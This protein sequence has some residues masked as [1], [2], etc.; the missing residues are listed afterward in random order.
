MEKKRSFEEI[1]KDAPVPQRELLQAFRETH[2][3]KKIVINGL[4]WEYISSGQGDQALLILGGGLSLGESSFRSI[5]H[6]ENRY[7]VISPSYPATDNTDLVLQGLQAILREEG[8]SYA[9]VMGHS[10]GSGVGH[11]FVRMC[12]ESVD[13]LVLDAFGLYTPAHVLIARLFFKLPFRWLMAYYRRA[14]RRLLSAAEDDDQK[15][16]AI[17]IGEVMNQLHTP[18]SLMYQ[19]KLLVDIFNK[20]KEYKV[21]EPIHKP[22]KVL[23]ILAEDDKGFSRKERQDLIAS[24]P[25]ALLHTFASGGHLAGFNRKDE[26]DRVVDQFLTAA[27]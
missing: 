1:Y 24:Y 4:Q 12:P 14:M 20:Q 7:H 13:K 22:G 18:V 8:Y 19:F 3:Y 23:L 6:M 17:Y 11:V 21:F 27:L 10:L 2:P 15:F 26:F 16:F 5:L 25:G 9:H